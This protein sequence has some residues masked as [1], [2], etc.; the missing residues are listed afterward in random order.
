MFFVDLWY[1]MRYG[2]IVSA[3]LLKNNVIYK[4]I[5]HADCFIQR[6]K[7]ELV[8]AKQGFVTANGKF[9]DRVLALKIAK[10]YN[11]I[12]YKHPPEDMLFSEDILYNKEEL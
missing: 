5:T 2:K 7:G 9:V 6:P 4:G 12:K 10:H 11:Q 8:N 1:D 3:A